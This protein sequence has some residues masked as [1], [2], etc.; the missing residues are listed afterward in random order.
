MQADS[1]AG[2]RHSAGP[3]GGLLGGY[4]Q[5]GVGGGVVL[6]GL[7][8]LPP[9]SCQQELRGQ[10]SRRGWAPCDR[11]QGSHSKLRVVSTNSTAWQ[12]PL[13]TLRYSKGQGGQMPMLG[14]P[15]R[16]VSVTLTQD[17]LKVEVSS[18]G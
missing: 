15:G 5:R 16:G 10:V 13:Q 2:T 9:A 11:V 14:T 1:I 3:V 4:C 17:A 18:S 6:K 7:R 12:E 8:P